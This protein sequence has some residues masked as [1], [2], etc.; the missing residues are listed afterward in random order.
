VKCETH[1]SDRSEASAIPHLLV[2]NTTHGRNDTE[3][4]QHVLFREG[5]CI[6][7]D[8]HPAVHFHSQDSEEEELSTVD[9]QDRL[10]ELLLKRF[11]RLRETLATAAEETQ[12]PD[13][14]RRQAQ[15]KETRC[16]PRSERAWSDTISQEHPNLAQ[17]VQLDS[18]AVY[19]GLR[20][21]AG[22]I[23]QA[24]S[25]SSQVSCWIWTLLAS[26]GDVGTLDN[27]KISR[28]RDLGLKAGLMGCRLRMVDD[29]GAETK[30]DHILQDSTC[31]KTSRDDVVAARDGHGAQEQDH[32]PKDIG[33]EKPES[34]VRSEVAHDDM[35]ES[36]AEMSMSG[37]EGQVHD[38]EASE[39]DRARARLLSQLGDRLVHAQPPPSA[40]SP[41]TVKKNSRSSNVQQDQGKRT[42]GPKSKSGIGHAKN[43]DVFDRRLGGLASYG[44]DFNT[45]ATI[46]MILTVVAECFGQRDLLRY[47][48]QW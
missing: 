9:P 7:V 15:T 43:N 33:R 48:Q 45:Q 23:D 4:D 21:C 30:P 36:D 12:T 32:T 1:T 40:T 24:S 42:E 20:S 34:H 11:Y 46:D 26:V 25:I 6:A 28:I 31:D 10:Y 41:K 8:E 44:V 38:V 5:T 29:K 27:E 13:T 22:S 14:Q 17:V 16:I 18:V 35:S 37:D 3:H 2:G 47:R 39:L 19:F